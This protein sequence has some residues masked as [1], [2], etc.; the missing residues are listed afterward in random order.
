MPW[1]NVAGLRDVL[2]HAYDEIDLDEVWRI[3]SEQVPQLL[4]RL[5]PLVPNEEE[6]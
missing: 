5:E 3:A 4:A 6:C 2:I 1:K